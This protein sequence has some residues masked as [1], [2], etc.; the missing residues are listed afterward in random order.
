MTKKKILLINCPQSESILSLATDNITFD[1]LELATTGYSNNY[2]TN[3]PVALYEYDLIC[4]FTGNINSI[5]VTDIT[6][7]KYFHYDD[8]LGDLVKF[9]Q[10]QGTLVLFLAEKAEEFIHNLGTIVWEITGASNGDKTYLSNSHVLGS[11]IINYMKKPTKNYLR[12]IKGIGSTIGAMYKNQFSDQ[13]VIKNKNGDVCALSLKYYKN[14]F[15]TETLFIVPELRDYKSFIKELFKYIADNNK[16]YFPDYQTNDWQDADTFMSQNFRKISLK[17]EENLKKYIE[18]DKE[19]EELQMKERENFKYVREILSEKDDK[20]KLGVKLCFEKILGLKVIDKDEERG[21]CMGED[22]EF[23]YNGDTYIIEVKGDSTQNPPMKHL[24]QLIK[25]AYKRQTDKDFVGELK[26]VLILNHDIN[27]AP[28]Q[29]VEPYTGKE[30]MQYIE[31]FHIH[32]IT[33][34]ELFL[35]LKSVYDKN[36]KKESAIK[37]LLDKAGK[38]KFMK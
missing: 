18:K 7:E 14:N 33:S 3:E 24:N 16:N 20:L 38:Y 15:S 12:T 28:D 17:R 34:Y 27:T 8:F 13:L 37:E 32:L 19:L 23:E 21:N 31:D 22:L 30:D 5:T 36:K 9:Y 1:R 25:H 29:R 2:W 4:L 10:E 11:T 35:L 26:P 6:E